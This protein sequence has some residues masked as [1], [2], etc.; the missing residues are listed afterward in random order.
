MRPSLSIASV[1][2]FAFPA[3]AAQPAID[4]RRGDDKLVYGS[5][6]PSLVA[7][8]KSTETIDYLQVDLLVTLSNGEQRGL[9][10]QSA[11]REGILYPIAPGGKALLQQ[12]L[13]MSRALGVPCDQV[14]GRKVTGIVCQAAGGRTCASPV[15]VEP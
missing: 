8:N 15:S 5:C 9:E 7:E 14:K 3:L 11:Y 1:F 12:H 6:V 2:L 4:V 10:L 13:D